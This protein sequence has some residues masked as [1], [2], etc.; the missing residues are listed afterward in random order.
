MTTQ[1]HIFFTND[2]GARSPALPSFIEELFPHYKLTVIVPDRPRSG[3]SKAISFNEP[4][5]FFKGPKFAEQTIIESSGTPGDAITWCL[6]YCPD[7]DL[8]ISGPNLGLNVSAHSILTSGTVG[9]A[10]EAALWKIP[11]IAFSI[12]TPSNT[13]FIPQDSDANY[14]E[15]AKHTREIINLI[16]EKG[17]PAGS[18]FLN[19]SFPA[20]VDANTPIEVA[21]PQRIRFTNRLKSRID[22]HGME[23]HWIHGKENPQPVKATDVYFS[24]K[25]KKIVISPICISLSEDKLIE[26]TRRFFQ[27]LL[28]K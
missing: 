14:K 10:I 1:F 25:E 23:Y 22:P 11:A 27:P 16:L 26:T 20:D 21:K 3:I 12:E 7:V 17:M 4:I 15:A 5:R 6:T 2:D 24:L 8:V 18:D 28:K 19:I 13:W 9:A